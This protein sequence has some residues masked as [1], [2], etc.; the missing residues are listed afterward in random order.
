MWLC[1]RFVYPYMCVRIHR[2]SVCIRDFMDSVFTYYIWIYSIKHSLTMERRDDSA[3]KTRI[4]C[5]FLL[6]RDVL[7]E[8]FV[9]T[10][11]QSESSLQLVSRNYPCLDTLDSKQQL[12]F[13]LHAI[14]F[15]T[16]TARSSSEI[17]H[18]H[19]T[20]LQCRTKTLT[21]RKS[22]Q[23]TLGQHMWFIYPTRGVA[24]TLC[25]LK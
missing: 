10:R 8:H 17:L 23:K 6:I 5:F 21:Y 12:G 3:P 4:S 24:R 9:P 19:C 14:M 16:M 25:H 13:C 22:K 20:S 7:Y 1:F 15:R 11:S 18:L 2:S